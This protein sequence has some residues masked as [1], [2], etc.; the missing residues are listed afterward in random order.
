MR[1]VSTWSR[2]GKVLLEEHVLPST[3]LVTESCMSCKIT[4]A[5]SVPA[6]QQSE[7]LAQVFVIY[8]QLCPPPRMIFLFFELSTTDTTSLA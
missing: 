5:A 3:A 2:K 8:F 1:V 6:R 7:M 4:K